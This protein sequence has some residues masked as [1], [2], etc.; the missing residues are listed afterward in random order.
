MLASTTAILPQDNSKGQVSPYYRFILASCPGKSLE[1]TLKSGQKL[2]GKCHT[3]LA[4]QFQITA[5]GVTHDIPYSSIANINIQRRWF[6]KLKDAVAGPYLF[7]KLA[8]TG[9]ELFKF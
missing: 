2:S 6:G 1:I 3:P 4:D 7:I 8:I 9:E 5:K